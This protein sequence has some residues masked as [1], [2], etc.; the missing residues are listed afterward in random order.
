MRAGLSLRAIDRV[1]RVAW[2]IADLQGHERL[3]KT[4]VASAISLRSKGIC[5]G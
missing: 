2:S 1:L 4:D 5:D 3:T